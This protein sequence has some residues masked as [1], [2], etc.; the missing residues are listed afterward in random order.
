MPN[1]T[2]KAVAKDAGVSIATVSRVLNK[3]YPVS[4]E[5]EQRVMRSVEKLN[6]YPN[7]VARSLKFDST[8]SIGLI[9]SDI[10]NSFFS[11]ISRSVEDVVMRKHYDLIVCSTDSQGDKE[12]SYIQLLLGKKVDGLVLNITGHN[13][14]FIRQIS[15][16]IPVVLCGRRVSSPEYK[17]DFADSDN[18]SGSYSLIKHLIDHGHRR[19]AILN[20]Q[21]LVSSARERYDG[22]CRAMAGIGI[23]VDSSYPYCYEGDFTTAGSGYEGARHLMSLP[24]PPTA[25]AAMNNE[26]CVGAMRYCHEHGIRIPEDVSLCS[27]GKIQNE[28]L[29]YVRP[30]YVVMDPAVIGTRIADLL[31]ERIE[32]KN[33]LANREVLFSAELVAGNGVRSI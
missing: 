20:G 19:I 5:L 6:Y 17:G 14:D 30:S 16:T 2:I 26:L 18:S 27:Y 32:H 9:V 21:M 3:N 25:I 22:F 33:R 15:H 1:I 11:T 12:L 8:L 31:L 28:D 4:S 13:D 29:M 24:E 23:T 10:S 7:S